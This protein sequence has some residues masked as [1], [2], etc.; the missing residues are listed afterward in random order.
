MPDVSTRTVSTR[1]TTARTVAGSGTGATSTRTVSTTGIPT[2]LTSVSTGRAVSTIPIGTAPSQSDLETINQ[3]ILTNAGNYL[4]L[5]KSIGPPYFTQGVDSASTINGNSSV[6]TNNPLTSS[7]IYGSGNPFAILGDAFTK[8]FGG[9]T[10]NPQPQQ[11]DT[12]VQP[13]GTSSGGSSIAIVLILGAIGVGVWYWY[14]KHHG[15]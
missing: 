13:V 7:P 1:D 12:I 2:S 5:A 9:S 15:G 10:Y 4:A 6:D 14:K 8:A 3:R 11:P